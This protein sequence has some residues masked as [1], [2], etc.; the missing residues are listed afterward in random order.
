VQTEKSAVAEHSMNQDHIIKLHDSDVLSGKTGYMDRLIREAIELEMH[1]H[2]INRE[3]GLILIKAW[4]PL[5][6][7]LKKGNSST[8]LTLTT[9]LVIS[10]QYRLLLPATTPWYEG[11]V[12]SVPV[13][14]TTTLFSHTLNTICRRTTRK[15]T[16][17]IKNRRKLEIKNKNRVHCSH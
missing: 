12:Q 14:H 4:K 1:P 11:I 16:H 9:T 17:D 5:L 15:I 2:N 6:H 10:L 13:Y 7:R 3:D 8:H